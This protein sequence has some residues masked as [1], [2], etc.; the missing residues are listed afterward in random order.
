MSFKQILK[1]WTLPISMVVGILG[2]YIFTQIESLSNAKAAIAATFPYL[3][4]AIIFVMLFFTYCKIDPKDLRP[5]R[6]HLW[7]ILFQFVEVALGVWWCVAYGDSEWMPLAEGLLACFIAPMAAVGAVVTQKIGGNPATATT[8][9]LISSTFTAIMVPL[10]YPI[11]EP[12]L[13]LSFVELFL[14]ILSRVFPTIMAPLFLSLLLWWLAPKA[15]EYVAE[16]SKDYNFYLWG[17]CT[18]VNTA[19]IVKSIDTYPGSRLMMVW[20][21]LV[22]GVVVVGHFYW[23]KTN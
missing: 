19:Q 18:V 8:Y 1:D 9:T 21:C 10:V 3:L 22:V 17:L 16:M 12:G 5:R 15:K 11:V 6:W 2:Y 7:L 23:G 13:E 20:I 14:R 4:P